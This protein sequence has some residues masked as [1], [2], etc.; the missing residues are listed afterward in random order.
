MLALLKRNDRQSEFPKLKKLFFSRGTNFGQRFF[1]KNDVNAVRTPDWAGN[2]NFIINIYTPPRW[3]IRSIP[4]SNCLVGTTNITINI[5]TVHLV[6]QY[7]LS[8]FPTAQATNAR[9]TLERP[10][11]SNQRRRDAVIS[12]CLQE[13]NK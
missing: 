3:V 13:C 5:N 2:Y 4:H 7:N 10:Y 9:R 1:L 11:H 8:Y 6:Y 12:Y